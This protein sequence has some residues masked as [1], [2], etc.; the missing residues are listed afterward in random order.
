MQN[1]MPTMRLATLNPDPEMIKN[2]SLSCPKACLEES[3]ETETSFTITNQ[4][5]HER[6][7]KLWQMPEGRTKEDAVFM[8]L[9]YKTLDVE[10]TR[11]SPQT[12]FDLLSSI[13][14]TLGLFLGGSIFSLIEFLL[15]TF[16][17]SLSMLG[18]FM[19]TALR[20]QPDQ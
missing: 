16:F 14:G 1:L 15:V 12:F 3:I 20:I 9:F 13:G 17:F 4:E 8:E 18:L 7:W 6:A 11:V 19:K 10:V 5:S 2:V